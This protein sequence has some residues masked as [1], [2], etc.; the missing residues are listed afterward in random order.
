M[1]RR[2]PAD[3]SVPED[4]AGS[5]RVDADS[6]R[7]EPRHELGGAVVPEELPIRAESTVGRL[8]FS[9]LSRRA[10]IRSVKDLL[11]SD[12]C[13]AV[14]LCGEDFSARTRPLSWPVAVH[15]FVCGDLKMI[16]ERDELN[17][18]GL[19]PSPILMLRLLGE[20]TAESRGG[21]L[22]AGAA[23]DGEENISGLDWV[24]LGEGLDCVTSDG[25]RK[26]TGGLDGDDTRGLLGL[27][28][29]LEGDD[30][31]VLDGLKEGLVGDNVGALRGLN[32]GRDGES[33]GV[34]LG[35]HEGLEGDNVGTRLE[36]AEGLDGDNV[37]ARLVLLLVRDAAA[38]D[39]MASR[40]WVVRLARA[41]LLTLDRLRCDPCRRIGS[42]NPGRDKPA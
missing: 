38:L 28:D 3:C 24:G 9:M 18:C 15:A 30:A 16:R 36:L 35:L 13:G 41:L 33:V 22:G 11:P 6:W 42:R 5:F 34:L 25:L 31:G 32:D 17:G 10:A 1:A 7:A 26:I 21:E 2:G 23:A 29:G 20:P 8:G 14:L 4:S 12:D 27:H 40:R 39:L 37:A 19:V